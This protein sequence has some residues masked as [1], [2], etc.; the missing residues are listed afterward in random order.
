[1][2]G[3]F[4][5]RMLRK[6]Y[7]PNE[8]VDIS[9]DEVIEK[10]ENLI[11]TKWL[12]IKPRQDFAF[13]MSYTML[14]KGWKISKFFDIDN[15]FVYWYCDIIE[16]SLE[17]DT[18]TFTDLLVDLKIYPDGRYEVLDMD[19]L[20]EALSMKIITQEQYDDALSK[21]NGLLE[22]VKAGKFPP[23]DKEY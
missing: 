3:G 21:L 16:S 13:G 9:N 8:V 1:M 6:R 5:M 18:Y 12:P 19:E 20:E 14:D 15:N 2:R 10:N 7:I 22:I 17:G 23:I 4:V 11:V